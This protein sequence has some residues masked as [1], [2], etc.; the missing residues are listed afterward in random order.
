MSDLINRELLAAIRCMPSGTE[1]QNQVLRQL[2]AARALAELPETE[3]DRLAADERDHES[4]LRR[5]FTD[6]QLRELDSE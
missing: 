4:D 2:I 6:S 1:K 3:A 5:G